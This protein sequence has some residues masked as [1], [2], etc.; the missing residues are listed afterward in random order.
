M[1]MKHFEVFVVGLSLLALPRAISLQAP[2]RSSVSRTISPQT[3]TE[4]PTALHYRDN[5]QDEEGI[6]KGLN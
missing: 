4:T 3:F 2:L 6:R 5:V 1:A